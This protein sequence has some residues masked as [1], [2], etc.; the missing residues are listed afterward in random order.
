MMKQAILFFIFHFSFFIQVSPAQDY[1][2]SKKDTAEVRTINK[3]KFYVYKVEKGETVYSLCR[4]FSVTEAELQ[5]YNPGLKDG[6][7]NKMK[8][9]IPAVNP[10]AMTVPAEEKK[11]EA[12]PQVSSLEVALLLPLRTDKQYVTED[13]LSDTLLLSEGLERETAASLEFYEGVLYSLDELAKSKKIKVKLRVYDTQ[14]DSAVTAKLLKS[15]ALQKSD[16]WIASGSN[17][18][19]KLISQAS[20]QQKMPLLS[21]SMSSA[22]IFKDNPGAVALLPSSL[23]QCREMGKACSRL[24]QGM[25]CILINTAVAKENERN[26]SFKAGWLAEEKSAAVREITLGNGKESALP[27]SLSTVRQNVVFIPSSNEDF[28]STLMAA[29]DKAAPEKKFIV[30]GIPTW[31]YF[32]TIDPSLME[33]LNT[34]LFATSYI[35]YENAEALLFRKHFRESYGNEPSDHAYQGFDVMR[36]LGNTWLVNGKDFPG[37]IDKEEYKGLFTDYHFETN[38]GMHENNFIQVVRYKD[39]NLEKVDAFTK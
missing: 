1:S 30:V 8:L 22:E 14:D 37:S 6:L 7:K 19:L 29:L 17:V 25:Q 20:K 3:K 18:L 34:Y 28:V 9:W 11:T 35:D 33:K 15:A 23:T 2:L 5:E 38:H 10:G 16:V 4:K 26:K 13:L 27:D 24:F 32:E 12:G 39:L 21:A 36:V 31:Q